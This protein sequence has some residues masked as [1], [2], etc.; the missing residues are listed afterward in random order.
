MHSL[1]PGE[2]ERQHGS[3]G[4]DVAGVTKYAF[5]IAP[6]RG[7][8]TKYKMIINIIKDGTDWKRLNKLV[9]P[10][11]CTK[12]KFTNNNWWRG[13]INLKMV[14]HDSWWTDSN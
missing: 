3:R 2:R 6:A 13:N 11:N 4:R 14:R 7:N 1:W 8:K 12:A 5:S 9:F 10:L